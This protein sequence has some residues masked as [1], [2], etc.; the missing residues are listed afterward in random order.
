MGAIMRVAATIPAL[1]LSLGLL[2]ACDSPS[3]K[4]TELQFGT[5]NTLATTGN[6][7]LVTERPRPGPDGIVRPIVCTEPRPD[8]AV[9][10]GRSGNFTANVSVPEKATVGGSGGFATTEV[11]TALEGRSAGVLALRDGL[12]AACQAYANG[13]IGHDAYAMILSQYGTLLVALVGKAD[14]AIGPGSEK[15]AALAAMIVTCISKYDETRLPAA[16]NPL[17][18]DRFCRR[19]LHQG[20]SYAL[21]RS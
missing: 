10:F 5:S 18:D 12:Y 3:L 6:L 11:V 16:R 15:R 13:V 1:C 21:T 17:L 4:V 9:A 7:R 2:T 14:G 8:Y 19:V 20:L